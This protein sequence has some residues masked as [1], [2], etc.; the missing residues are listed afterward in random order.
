MKQLTFLLIVFIVV[1]C[2]MR[3]ASLNHMAVDIETYQRDK[4]AISANYINN[5]EYYRIHHLY[6]TDT[7][8]YKQHYQKYPYARIDPA[9]FYVPYGCRIVENESKFISSPYPTNSQLNV[10]VDTI[11]YDN[12]GN[13]FITF[14]CIE[15]KFSKIPYI[16]DTAHRFD[17]RAMIGYRDTSDNSIKVYPLTNF[18]AIGLKNKEDALHSIKK[19]YMNNLK[20]SYLAG[21]VYGT[22]KFEENIGDNDFFIKSQLFKKYDSKHYL[23]QMYK[24]LGEISEYKYPFGN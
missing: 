5:I 12:T 19:D 18:M 14:I 6:D 15:N 21:S 7:V 8:D 11:I 9:N 2:G 23:F 22:A 17:G 24:D 1:S 13:L 3:S 16:K 4:Q 20:G 10:S